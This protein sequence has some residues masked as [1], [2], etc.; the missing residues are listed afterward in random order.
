MSL[1]DKQEVQDIC[2]HTALHARKWSGF[3]C[4][5]ASEDTTL[6]LSDTIAL[7]VLKKE[8][9]LEERRRR[10]PNRDFLIHQVLNTN[11][12]DVQVNVQSYFL[13]PGLAS[14]PGPLGQ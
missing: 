2:G 9:E 12:S 1:L 14:N 5:Q 4:K 7:G 10:M 8:E 6:S 11:T 13:S 3:I